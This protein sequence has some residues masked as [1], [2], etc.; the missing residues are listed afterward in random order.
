M[1]E[2]Q[3]LIRFHRY[4]EGSTI[5]A[6]AE[7]VDAGWRGGISLLPYKSRRHGID[8]ATITVVMGAGSAMSFRL[9]EKRETGGWFT[10]APDGRVSYTH[11]ERTEILPGRVIRR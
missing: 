3:R 8:D 10:L 1:T 4:A 6:A 9:P 5:L 11:G 7:A 2:R